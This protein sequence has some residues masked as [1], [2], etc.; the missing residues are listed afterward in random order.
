MVNLSKEECCACAACENICPKNAI[1]FKED[2]FGYKYPHID[3]S[4]CVDCGLCDRICPVLSPVS[5][6]YPHEVYAAKS[7]EPERCT[8]SASGGFVA[9]LAENIIK[10]GGIVYGCYAENYQTI[11]HIRVDNVDDL[12]KIKNSKYVQSDIR[13]TYR[14]ALYDLKL[15]KFVLFIGTPCQIAG[16]RSFLRKEYD[17]LLTCD[18]VCHGVPALKIIGVR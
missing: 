16:L 14:D 10:D 15:N 17:N 12:G 5:K 7:I 11:G 8:E 13:H 3:V 18:F 2:D 4:R 6:S 9:S 1:S